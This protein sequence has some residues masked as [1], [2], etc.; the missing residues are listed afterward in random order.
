MH[1]SSLSPVAWAKAEFGGAELGDRRRTRRLAKVAADLARRPS[2]TLPT[3]IR[4]WCSLKAAYRMLG[5]DDVRYDQVIAPHLAQTRQRCAAAGHCL[6]IEDTTSLDYTFHGATKG[7]GRIGDNGGRGVY[8]H[9]TLAVSF[10]PEEILGVFAQQCW[11][12]PPRLDGKS[13]HT[14]SRHQRLKRR[15]ESDRWAACLARV[16]CS[17]S[18]YTF[19]ADREADIYEVFERCSEAKVGMIIRVRADRALEGDDRNVLQAVRESPVRGTIEVTVRSRDGLPA[20]K[21]TL[22]IRSSELPIRSPSHRPGQPKTSMQV[23]MMI[24]RELGAPAKVEPIQWVLLTTWAIETLTQCQR[25]AD[26]YGCRWLIE[27][28][29]K[30]IKSGCGVERSQLSD[31]DRLLRLLAIVAVLAVRLL[32][33]KLVARRDPDGKQISKELGPAVI[34]ILK[35]EFGTPQ[36]GWTNRQMI[37][38]I[39]RMGGFLARTGDGEPG[40]ITIWRGYNEL[41]LLA[42]GFRLGTRC[43]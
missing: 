30:C 3:S 26:A 39:A 7:L 15:R 35:S 42:E 20:R 5:N 11:M 33:M 2:G 31:G 17:G 16:D 22:E 9:T 14:E 1:A 38:H 41:M 18:G 19:V 37:R 27:E 12:R 6:L 36:G 28:Y 29:H 23:N 40:W 34:T 10:D 32:D 21:A 8:V 13:T 4:R 25:V 24:L 43:G